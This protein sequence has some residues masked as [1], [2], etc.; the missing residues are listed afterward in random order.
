M[1]IQLLII[2]YFRYYTCASRREKR[3]II[4][5]QCQFKFKKYTN[6]FD[7]IELKVLHFLIDGGTSFQIFGPISYGL[8]A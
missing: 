5:A 3:K 1:H 2:T 6:N 7:L 4:I 8:M